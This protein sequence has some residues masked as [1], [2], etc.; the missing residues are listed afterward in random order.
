MDF[1]KEKERRRAALRKR[2]FEKYLRNAGISRNRAKKAAARL[3]T[4]G[5]QND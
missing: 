1:L 4:N 2:Q 3:R 5:G